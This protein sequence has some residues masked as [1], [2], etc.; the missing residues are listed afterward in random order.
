MDDGFSFLECK[1]YS[2]Y[3]IYI[4]KRGRLFLLLYKK[5]KDIYVV[6]RGVHYCRVAYK[7]AQEQL[8]K[9]PEEVEEEEDDFQNSEDGSN[10]SGLPSH[11][12]GNKT[13]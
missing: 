7:M 9:L 8:R 12:S 10:N 1:L 4:Y 13:G 11:V 3:L 6:Y 5:V 2:V